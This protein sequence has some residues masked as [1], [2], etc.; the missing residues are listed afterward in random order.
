MCCGDRSRRNNTLVYPTRNSVRVGSTASGRDRKGGELEQTTHHEINIFANNQRA[1]HHHVLVAQIPLLVILGENSRMCQ[2][3]VCF[4][5]DDRMLEQIIGT[6]QIKEDGTRTHLS[7]SGRHSLTSC[8]G[9]LMT[10]STRLCHTSLTWLKAE[11]IPPR[12]SSPITPGSCSQI[13]GLSGTRARRH[14][15]FLLCSSFVL[16]CGAGGTA[17]SAPSSVPEVRVDSSLG[18]A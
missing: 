12:P 8:L 9:G 13:P 4:L 17:S 18:R 11:N 10:R 2:D 7:I 14:S 15:R 3:A 6:R 16:L 5:R 1:P